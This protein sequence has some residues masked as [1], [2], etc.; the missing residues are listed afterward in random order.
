MKIG[1]FLPSFLFTDAGE[2]EP[3]R[4]RTFARRAEDLGFESLWITDHIITA[5][6][7]YRV[8]W[9]DSLIT[10]SHAA[11]ITSEIRL[12]TSI[13]I[14][15]LRQPA[16][17]AKEVAT[18][19]HLSGNRY[20]FG[21]GVGWYG[22]EF[23]ACGVDKSERGARTDEVIDATLALLRESDVEFTGRY[24]DLDKVT[25]EPHPSVP[26]PTWIGGGRQ[27]EHAA[28]PE[29][30]QMNPAV[31][32]RIARHNGWI[33]RPTCPADLIKLDLAEIRSR[34]T[35][36]GIAA[37][38][39]TI[40]HENFTWIQESGSSEEIATEQRRRFGQVVSDE[41]PWDYI[42]ATYLTGS[43]DQIQHKIQ[44]RADAGVEHLMLHTLT[45]DVG[46]LELMAKHVL[47]PFA[48]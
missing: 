40:A 43:V 34:R 38:P 9:L 18:L 35:E 48:T 1:V 13:L 7:F 32:E 8:S 33:A 11:A 31:L 14:A 23:T 37:K 30:A 2:D 3:E 16:L 12:G 29:K 41:R 45:S 26:P 4:L 20:I 15:P 6:R 36:L 19:H 46:Q 42:D 21:V 22:P 24:Y 27:L 17:L 5:K 44:D 10:L 28:S 25:V 47:R 39:F